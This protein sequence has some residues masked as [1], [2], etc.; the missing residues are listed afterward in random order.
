VVDSSAYYLLGYTSPSR[1]DGQYHPIGVNVKRRG[2]EVR[3]RHGYW[4]LKAEDAA[5]LAAGPVVRLPNPI[6]VALADHVASPTQLVRT[7]IGLSRG[8]AGRTHVKISWE[9]A[10]G[11]EASGARAAE[12]AALGVTAFGSGEAPLFR[13]RSLLS[14][15]STAGRSLTFDLPPGTAQI[16]L[17]VEA[18]DGFELDTQLRALLVPDLT[19]AA[20]LGTPEVFVGRTPAD[21]QSIK[22]DGDRA[23]STRREFSRTEQLFV[24]VPRYAPA[25]S[26]VALTA[27]LMNRSNQPL[28]TLVVQDGDAERAYLQFPLAS[29][30]PGEYGIEFAASPESDAPRQIVAFRVT[31]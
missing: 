12:I 2:L 7:W 4:A 9:P 20:S 18:V 15:G 29:L 23:P 28:R 31:P 8:D 13:G 21:M 14:E 17:A 6:E 11:R 24:K 26:S 30:A 5:R 3:A 1:P 22:A 10:L 19:A 25:G 16:R 27:R